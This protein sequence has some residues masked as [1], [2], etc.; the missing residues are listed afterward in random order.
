MKPEEEIHRRAVAE[1]RLFFLKT[2]GFKK[3][4]SPFFHCPNESKAPVQY[5]AKMDSMGLS[6]GVPDLI[7]VWPTW[8][9]HVGAALEIKSEKGRETPAQKAWLSRLGNAGFAT[10]CTKGHAATATQLFEWGYISAEQLNL[11]LAGIKTELIG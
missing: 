10:A 6:S 5:R 4:Q 11:W 7:V 8:Q 3:K 2:Q 1:L 9:G